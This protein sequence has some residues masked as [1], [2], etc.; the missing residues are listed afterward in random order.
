MAKIQSHSSIITPTNM[1]IS[2]EKK[3]KEIIKLS[4]LAH[5]ILA[6]Q[7]K[8]VCSCYP[9]IYFNNLDKKCKFLLLFFLQFHLILF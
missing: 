3:R 7:L 4:I 1:F 6:S 2:Q 5:S 9:R 8:A